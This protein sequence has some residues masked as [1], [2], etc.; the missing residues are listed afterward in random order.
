MPN[1]PSAVSL[2]LS[3]DI[4]LTSIWPDKSQTVISEVSQYITPLQE[5]SPSTAHTSCWWKRTLVSMLKVTISS[6][7][8][9]LKP[10][11]SSKTIWW[12]AQSF[13]T[14]CY[15]VTLQSPAIGSPIPTT[16]LDATTQQVETSMGSGM[17]LR[18]TLTDPVPPVIS[19]PWVWD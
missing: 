8:M 18:N 6:W 19:A 14:Q 5:S 7:K 3:V 9:V 13:L 10:T 2:K 12:W 16:Q 4:V 15:K 1:S 11:M 17:K